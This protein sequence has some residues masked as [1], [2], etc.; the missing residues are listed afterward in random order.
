MRLA[1]LEDMEVNVHQAKTHLSAL[2]ERAE[3]GEEIIIARAGK[4]VARLIPVKRQPILL[5]VDRGRF[6]VPPDF[7]APLPPDVLA[8]FYGPKSLPARRS[9]TKRR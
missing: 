8:R 7:D 2:L 3:R 1:R 5:G 6:E 4:A 9:R